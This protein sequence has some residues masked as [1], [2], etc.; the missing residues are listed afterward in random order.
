MQAYAVFAIS[1][2]LDILVADATQRRAR[3]VSKPSLRT[4]L[5]AAV[6]AFRTASPAGA[7]RSATATS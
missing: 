7:N 2:Q 4:R 6:L 3:R 5:A 1:E